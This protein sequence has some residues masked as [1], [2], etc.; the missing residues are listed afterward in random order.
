MSKNLN[1]RLSEEEWE[2]LEKYCLDTGRSKTALFKAIIS[3]LGDPNLEQILGK[4]RY[5][6]NS[7]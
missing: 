7:D 4:S 2:K 1:I 6:G 5:S 3:R